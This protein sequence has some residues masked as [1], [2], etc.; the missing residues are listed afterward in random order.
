MIPHGWN[1]YQRLVSPPPIILRLN[2]RDEVR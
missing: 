2:H 1:L